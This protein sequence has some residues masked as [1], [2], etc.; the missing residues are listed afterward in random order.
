MKAIV[1]DRFGAPAEVLH[2]WDVPKPTPAAGEVLIKIKQTP[3]NPADLLRVRGKY[4]VLPTLPAT[5]GFEGVGV[6]EETR[7]GVLGRIRGLKPGKRVAVLNRSTGNW[8]QYVAIP[9][10]QAV[11]LPDDIADHHA[12]TFFVNPATSLVMTRYVLQVPPGAWLL[13]TAAGS[14][15]GK[16]V[17]RLGKHFGFK[18]INLV[19]RPDA[20]DELK[21]LG[22]DEVLVTERDDVPKRVQDIT[23]GQGVKYAL[24]CV[25]GLTGQAA[26][27]ALGTGGTLLVYGTLSPDPI[28]LNPRSLMVGGKRIQGFWLSEWTTQQGPLR[29]LRLFREIIDLIRKDVLTSPVQAT[30]AM[31]QIADAVTAAETPGRTGKILLTM[32]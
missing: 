32:P 23:D 18:T 5:P 10:R 7:V 4:G 9:W 28:P 21:K 14:A 19:R 6:I 15:L 20:V 31:E 1:F 2:V 13:Q 12:A 24:D 29:M 25:G 17:I 16:M 8:Q 26:V 30:Y 27:L 11:P 3:I 22:A